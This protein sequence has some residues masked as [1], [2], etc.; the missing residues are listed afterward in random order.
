[1]FRNF[2]GCLVLFAVS[3]AAAFA[4]N[5][6]LT[7]TV[8]DRSGARIQNAAVDFHNDQN[9]TSLHFIT[10]GAGFYS[11]A[12]PPGFYTINISASGFQAME[13]AGVPL[14]V[15]ETTTLNFTLQPGT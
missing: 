4:Q 8:S 14:D 13:R 7:G 11:A 15:A 12:V 9:G 3:A 5:A 2:L 10:D 6:Q 1:M